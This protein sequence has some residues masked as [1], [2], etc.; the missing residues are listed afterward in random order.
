ML[1]HDLL[2]E[3]NVDN[4]RFNF[5][6][7]QNLT[8]KNNTKD[9]GSTKNFTPRKI[10]AIQYPGNYSTNVVTVYAP[11]ECNNV[12]NLEWRTLLDAI[13]EF[14]KFLVQ[15]G[16]AHWEA[17]QEDLNVSTPCSIQQTL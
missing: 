8:S 11:L 12:L 4:N 15:R 16:Q 9:H 1:L 2:S 14:I 17:W 6:S 5:A 7:Y 13:K 10:P 3:H